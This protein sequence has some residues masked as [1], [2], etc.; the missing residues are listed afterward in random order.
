MT[1]WET[2]GFWTYDAQDG[3]RVPEG[4]TLIN[5]PGAM[6]QY[7]WS[8]R[9]QLNAHDQLDP[10]PDRILWPVF[11]N[12]RDHRVCVDGPYPSFNGYIDLEGDAYDGVY[13]FASCK[14]PKLIAQTNTTPSRKQKGQPPGCPFCLNKEHCLGVVCQWAANRVIFIACLFHLKWRVNIAQIN[15]DR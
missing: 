10:R 9:L 11:L 13:A 6:G 3:L 4:L 2:V 12:R 8:R 14:G 7:S 15:H 5:A 1:V